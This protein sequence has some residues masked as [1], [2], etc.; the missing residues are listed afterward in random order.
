MLATGESSPLS[1]KPVID[2]T[3]DLF[4]PIRINAADRYIEHI[5]YDKNSFLSDVTKGTTS[6]SLSVT[7]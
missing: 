1:L 6:P 2:T 4:G 7:V 5:W 3:S